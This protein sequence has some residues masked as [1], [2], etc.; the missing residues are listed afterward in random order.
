MRS[1]LDSF[2]SMAELSKQKYEK[3]IQ[4]LSQQLQLTYDQLRDNDGEPGMICKIQVGQCGLQQNLSYWVV[5]CAKCLWQLLKFGCWPNKLDSG[6]LGTRFTLWL[7]LVLGEIKNAEGE[8][9]E[10]VVRLGEKDCEIDG[11]KK[12]LADSLVELEQMRES[13]Q[14]RLLLQV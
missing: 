2:N 4:E 7:W 10:Y 14:V 3:K 8:I 13:L 12:K 9:N 5:L 1:D 11:L 6:L